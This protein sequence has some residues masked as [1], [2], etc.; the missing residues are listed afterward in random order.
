MALR[1]GDRAL[2]TGASR[3]I[4]RALAHA[5]AAR[6]IVVGLVA[7]DEEQ[8]RALAAELPGT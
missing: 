1:A 3:G 5:L 8:L 4:G 7:R 2:V 6:G